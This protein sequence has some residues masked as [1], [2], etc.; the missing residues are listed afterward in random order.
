MAEVIYNY[1]YTK[2]AYNKS[3]SLVS[4]AYLFRIE[5]V[6]NSVDKTNKK[7]NVTINWYITG[8]NGF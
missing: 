8:Q 7:A 5:A 3:G 1:S 2:G 4:N 6:L